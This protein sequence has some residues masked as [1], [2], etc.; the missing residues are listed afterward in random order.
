MSTTH[1]QHTGAHT[2]KRVFAPSEAVPPPRV[3]VGV[4]YAIAEGAIITVGGTVAVAASGS[5]VQWAIPAAL[6]TAVA[7]VALDGYRR[8]HIRTIEQAYLPSPT[9]GDD[10]A[11]PAR[12]S[13]RVPVTVWKRTGKTSA[14]RE[15][16]IVTQTSATHLRLVADYIAQN[17]REPLS[18]PKLDHFG[19]A[20][21]IGRFS[22][23][24]HT[25][26]KR[27][28]IALGF[29]D[30]GEEIGAISNEG[31]IW[32]VERF[33]T[34]PDATTP[35]PSSPHRVWLSRLSVPR[36]S[37]RGAFSASFR[38]N[39]GL[40][41]GVQGV[42]VGDWLVNVATFLILVAAFYMLF[43]AIEAML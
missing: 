18:R 4:A 42:A 6:G 26:F 14:E 39:L 8:L 34:S 41:G 28:L 35:P 27:D 43:E 31:K 19:L 9:D 30:E 21:K 7:T 17:P 40:V 15:A 10:D 38:H 23:E 25:K 1:T 29:L 11:Q 36:L 12:R 2:I 16:D 24:T 32:L 37:D 22:G 3:R 33:A 5:G 20:N 13:E